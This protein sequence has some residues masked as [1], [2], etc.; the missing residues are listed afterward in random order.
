VPTLEQIVVE[1]SRCLDAPASADQRRHDAH[2][3]EA[4]DPTAAAAEMVQP[5]T[6]SG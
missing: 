5:L 4:A 3:P 1:R 2:D 6:N